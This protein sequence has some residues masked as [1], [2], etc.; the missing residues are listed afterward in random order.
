MPARPSARS[1]A[2]RRLA[3]TC[4]LATSL[5]LFAGTALAQQQRSL[6]V[7]DPQDTLLLQIGRAH[8]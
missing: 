8:V 4:M 7:P 2:M 6:Q 3:C 5:A 1:S